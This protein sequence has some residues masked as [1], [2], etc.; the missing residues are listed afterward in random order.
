MK[1]TVSFL[2]LLCLFFIPPAIA[3]VPEKQFDSLLDAQ[4]P[5][6]GPGAVVL[7]AKEGT[8]LYEK[9]FGLAN[10]E[11]SL[12]MKTTDVFRIGSN[13]KQFTAVAILQLAEAGKLTLQDDITKY[14][15]TY[16]THGKKITI[17]NLLTHTSGIANY[18]GLPGFNDLKRKSMTPIELVAFFKDA[19]MDF[20]P[21]T[22]FRYDN[23]GY[24]LLGYIIEKITGQPYARYIRENIFQ[25]AGMIHSFYDLPQEL[26]PDRITGYKKAGAHYVNADFLDMSLPYAAG[27]LLSTAGDLCRWYRTLVSGKI[28]GSASLQ[29]AW[30]SYRLPG[31]RP[32]GY[33]YGWFTG[34]VRGRPAVKH[35]GV[36]NGFVTYTAYLPKEKITVVILSN[37]E[38]TGDLN[39]PASELIAA[40]LGTPYRFN[41]LP[42]HSAALQSYQ[43]VYHTPYDGDKIIQILDGHLEFFYKGG[44]KQELL[45]YGKDSFYIP[46]TLISLIFERNAAG[47]VTGFTMNSTEMPVVGT[48]T[49]EKV[50]AQTSIRLSLPALDQYTG[51]YQFNGF[52]LEIERTDSTLYGKVGNDRKELVPLAQD[53]FIAR[54]TDATLLFI[55]DTA[56]KIAGMTK[57]QNSEMNARKIELEP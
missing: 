17:E 33:G 9:A 8:V 19:P 45:P 39:L 30:S 50:F 51:K 2:N 3:Q 40:A 21:G 4:F 24:I 42:L 26:I 36:V 16:P 47:Q 43:G 54:D 52:V 12:P 37:S 38:S 56:G 5:T 6:G 53:K 15:R 10:I 49:S 20:D 44:R 13:T 57:V 29:K 7:L 14:I 48:L 27:A 18:T 55:R 23:S 41:S 46:H 34:N 11:Q 32:T 22:D 1:L 25:P 28:I 35:V 31:G